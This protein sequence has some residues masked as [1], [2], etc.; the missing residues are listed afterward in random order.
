[1][2]VVVNDLTMVFSQ[3]AGEGRGMGMF[4]ITTNIQSVGCPFG[5][6]PRSKIGQEN[7]F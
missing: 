1:M 2:A 3:E 7:E 6:G 5:D 4:Y